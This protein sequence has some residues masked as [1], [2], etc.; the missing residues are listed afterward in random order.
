MTRDPC[1][2]TRSQ[3]T[4]WGFLALKYIK[5]I[6]SAGFPAENE[7]GDSS[8]WHCLYKSMSVLYWVVFVLPL[9]PQGV[10]RSDLCF[11]RFCLTI[12]CQNRRSPHI[13][14]LCSLFQNKPQIETETWGLRRSNK[15]HLNCFLLRLLCCSLFK[16]SLRLGVFWSPLLFLPFIFSH[17]W[18]QEISSERLIQSHE[19]HIVLCATRQQHF[20]YGLWLY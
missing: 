6:T 5:Y 2:K 4:K 8:N 17:S 12:Q 9:E 11:I 18:L 20:I 15:T 1:D 13:K 16:K 3:E 7:S 19:L 14:S 10:L